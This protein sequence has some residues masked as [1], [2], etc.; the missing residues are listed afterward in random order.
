MTTIITTT[1]MIT[2]HLLGTTTANGGVRSLEN[3][4]VIYW[5]KISTWTSLKEIQNQRK[6][7]ESN[8]YKCIITK[9]ENVE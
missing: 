9:L 8:H 2:H 6:P 5:M 7:R 1:T 4:R 3:G